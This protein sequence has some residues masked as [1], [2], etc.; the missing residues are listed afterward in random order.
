MHASRESVAGQ[1][2]DSSRNVFGWHGSSHRYPGHS[3]YWYAERMNTLVDG[4]RKLTSP[5]ILS[6]TTRHRTSPSPLCIAQYPR[7]LV[8]RRS[9]SPEDVSSMHLELSCVAAHI[10]KDHNDDQR[11]TYKAYMVA[12]WRDYKERCKTYCTADFP[13]A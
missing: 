3:Q 4:V 12:S 1:R 7:S 10:Y 5:H 2:Y 13:A 8:R 6:S 11:L 9:P